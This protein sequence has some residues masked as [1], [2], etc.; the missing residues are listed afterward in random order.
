MRGRTMRTMAYTERVRHCSQ[1]GVGEGTMCITRSGT[2]TKRPHKVRLSVVPM[3]SIRYGMVG[4]R[5]G[6]FA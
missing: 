3:M 4:S 1:C 6:S 2:F 5:I